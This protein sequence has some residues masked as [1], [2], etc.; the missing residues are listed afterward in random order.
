MQTKILTEKRFLK[1]LGL[2]IISFFLIIM[3]GYV[4]LN[5][6]TAVLATALYIGVSF[7]AMG[8]GYLMEA[9]F[10]HSY[11]FCITGL[12]DI[13]LGIVL[14]GNLAFTMLSVPF[15]LGVWCL[16][17]GIIYLISG[18]KIEGDVFSVGRL[19]MFS[20]VV[21]ILFGILILLHPW[22]GIFTV[23]FLIGSYFILCGLFEIVRYF[24]G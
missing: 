5:P 11:L 8:I 6:E 24:K 20:G 2:L 9:R 7:I 15:I 19:T 17:T 18:A 13:L 10:R 1:N 4:L 12:I 22:L 14:L 21:G 3:G 23:S 16:M